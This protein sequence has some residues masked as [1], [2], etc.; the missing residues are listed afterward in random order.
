MEKRMPETRSPY[1]VTG[2]PGFGWLSSFPEFRAT[3]ARSIR[4]ALASFV[5]DAGSRQEHAWADSIPPLQ[6][7]VGE[8]L[9]WQRA[10]RNYSALLEYELPYEL[11]RPDVIFLAGR[12]LFVLELKGKESADRADI[13]QASAYARDLR[14]YHRSCHDRPVHSAL[15]LTRASGRLGI[16]AG[17][18]VVGMDAIDGL[19]EELDEPQVPPAISPEEFLRAD[20]YCPAPTLIEAAR[21]IAR[22]YELRWVDRAAANTMPAIDAV[23]EI[24]RDAARL[25]GRRLVLLTGAPGAGKT[26]VGIKIAHERFLDD[27]AV[28]RGDGA[29]GAPAVFLSG[30][31]PLVQVLQYQ[32]RDQE[33]RGRTFVRGVKEYVNWYT[34]R[35]PGATPPEH[36]LIYDEAQRAWDAEQVATRHGEYG[37]GKSEPEHFVEFAQR[38]P[39]WCVVIGLIGQGQEIHVGEEAGLGQWERAVA[40]SARAAEW[41]VFLPPNAAADFGLLPRTNADPRLHLGGSTRFHFAGDVEDFVADLVEGAESSALAPRSAVL[42]AAGFHLRITRDL[43]AAKAYLRERYADDS[44]ARFGMLSSARDKDLIRFG[45]PNQVS[46]TRFP[47]GA[48]YVEGDGDYLGRS[49][50][51]LRDCVTEFGAQGLE[52][53]AT[54]LAWGTDFARNDGSWTNM[55]AKR[56]LNPR[57]V[58]DPFHLRQNAYRVLLTRGRD[59]TVVFVPPIPF[60]D[61]TFAYLVAA[62]FRTL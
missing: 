44:D 33:G 60:L 9:D 57:R 30:N 40:G 21:E 61:E 32:L 56:Y 1:V 6:V 16:D 26:L 53:D 14:A 15:V 17:V 41:S 19:I 38:I 11:R 54:L 29:R 35:H 45:V 5:T 50:R 37:D 62:G 39:R 13:D 51:T 25:G 34:T 43:D 48:W 55:L 10:S 31:G 59:G 23:T 36:V 42:D 49:C 7:E 52:L 20:S 58:R 18:H 12:G 8:V 2:I 24:I 27:L 47:Y 4:E 28:P 22:T 46:P 3:P